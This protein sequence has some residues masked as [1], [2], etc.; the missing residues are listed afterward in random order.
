MIAELLFTPLPYGVLIG[1]VLRYLVGFSVL[2]LAARYRRDRAPGRAALCL[3]LAG[4]TVLGGLSTPD[5]ADAGVT[6][7]ALV[8]LLMI[9]ALVTAII[10]RRAAAEEV[11]RGR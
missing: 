2:V 11:R 4:W 3:A 8:W 10:L 5:R 1:A 9:Y 7:Y 6:P